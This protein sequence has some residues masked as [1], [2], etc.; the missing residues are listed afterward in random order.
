MN[1][2]KQNCIFCKIIN[3]E[4]PSEKIYEDDMV[5]SFMDIKPVS[6]GH[7]L[8]IPK[9]HIPWMQ[10]SSDEIIEYIFK[11]AKNLMQTLKK[12]LN[13]DFVQL[14][15]VGE[16]VPHFHIHLIP[17]Y[18]DDNLPRWVTKNYTEGEMK[19]YAEK[20]KTNI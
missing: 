16:E 7:I 8:L 1:P 6:N 13:C 5:F 20:I 2:V 12:S 15:I 14:S 19:E 17:R 9:E 3:K 11:K 18:F 4:I 10:D